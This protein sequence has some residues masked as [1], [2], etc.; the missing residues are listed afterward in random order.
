MYIRDRLIDGRRRGR[1]R[2]VRIRY[3]ARAGGCL[4]ADA[5][6]R[7]GDSLQR[8]QLPVRRVAACGCDSKIA[9]QTPVSYTHL[10]VYKRQRPRRRPSMSRPRRAR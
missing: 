6:Q 3:V 7:G 8:V 4:H 10:D 9:A 5:A 2:Y 1:F